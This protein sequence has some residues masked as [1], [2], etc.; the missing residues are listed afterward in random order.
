MEKIE[1]TFISSIDTPPLDIV[2]REFPEISVN[3]ED[4]RNFS[5]F[6]DYSLELSMKSGVS[7]IL[8]SLFS[9]N[10]NLW[11]W[12]NG[13][14]DQ[15]RRKID[16]LSSEFDFGNRIMFCELL[17][18]KPSPVSIN[19]ISRI[20]CCSKEKMLVVG[21]H[22]VDELASCHAGVRFEYSE[23]FFLNS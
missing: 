9:T 6:G 18:P 15:Q 13:N 16:V 17:S 11:I 21:D 10:K 1:Q 23:V 14:V 5:R 20:E 8:E 19:E 3:I 2:H 7:G 22:K 4:Y 12:T